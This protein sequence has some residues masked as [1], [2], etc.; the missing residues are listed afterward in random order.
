M[1]PATDI[2]LPRLLKRLHLPTI[3][4]LLPDIETRAAAEGWGIRDALAILCAEEVANRN[5]TRIQKAIR[6]ARFPFLKTIEEF[7]FTFGTGLRRDLLAPYL[8]REFITEGRNLILSGKSGRGKTSLAIATGIRAIQNGFDARFTTAAA[9]ID[10]LVAAAQRGALA[11]AT[12]TYREP[13]VLIIDEVG[14]LPYVDD[15]ANVLYGVVD[16]RYL[17]HRPIIFTTNKSLEH[18]GEVLHDDH[19][20]EALLDRVLERGRL[21]P[22]TGPSYRTRHLAQES[23]NP[24]ESH[25]PQP[26][27]GHHAPPRS[28]ARRASSGSSAS[29]A[30]PDLAAGRR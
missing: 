8:C 10:E 29:K 28:A 12:A 24:G 19:L 9:L 3:A 14:Y 5:N 6:N 2:D 30:T 27:G 1:T 22:L 26:A 15:A 21:L 7:D 18:W 16:G 25:N 11:E 4:R 23:Q 13:D 17:D 20:A